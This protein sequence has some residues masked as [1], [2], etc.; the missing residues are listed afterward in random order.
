MRTQT[1]MKIEIDNKYGK[2]TVSET[3]QLII[4]DRIW[5]VARQTSRGSLS[6]LAKVKL[7]E[8]AS[9]SNIHWDEKK[10]IKESC[11]ILEE[12]DGDFFCDCPVGFKGGLWDHTVGMHYRNET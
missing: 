8:R 7:T 2:Y 1:V 10:Q 9:L 12:R 4:V 5:V 3:A 6:D 11:W